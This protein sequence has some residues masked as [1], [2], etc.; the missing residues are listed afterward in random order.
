[1]LGGLEKRHALNRAQEH[2]AIRRARVLRELPSDA[3]AVGGPITSRQ[4]CDSTLHAH[5]FS[6]VHSP[7]GTLIVT[8]PP[9]R[10]SNAIRDSTS[11]ASA[12][13]ALVLRPRFLV[14]SAFGGSTPATSALVSSSAFS[15][16]GGFTAGVALLFASILALS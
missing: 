7:A 16:S 12:L 10:F 5:A 6:A 9:K 14:S 4:G 8:V 15:A 11:G 3:I 2:R 13:S 1:E